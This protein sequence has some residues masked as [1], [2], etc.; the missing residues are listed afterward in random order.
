MKHTSFTHSLRFFKVPFTTFCMPCSMCHEV[1]GRDSVLLN[2]LELKGHG[3]V[4]MKEEDENDHLKGILLSLAL[5]SNKE[6]AWCCAFSLGR[7]LPHLEKSSSS[8]LFEES[9]KLQWVIQHRYFTFGQWVMC[10]CL[11]WRIMDKHIKLLAPKY[12]ET[13]FICVDAE[14]SSCCCYTIFSTL[15]PK[16]TY[17]GETYISP[18]FRSTKMFCSYLG[19][20]MWIVLDFAELSLLCYKAGNQGAALCPPFQV[21]YR[22]TRVWF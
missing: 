11:M 21:H 2:M 19:I 18:F 1:I 10:W 13:K 9:I 22:N 5:M 3:K 20:I 17:F 8:F 6:R 14:V 7:E 16:P 4:C 15:N 12:F